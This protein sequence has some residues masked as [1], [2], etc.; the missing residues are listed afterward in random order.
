MGPFV[1]IFW[2]PPLMM[3]W[4]ASDNITFIAGASKIQ[5]GKGQMPLKPLYIS[6]WVWT[7]YLW[8]L[9]VCCIKGHML[10]A[11][12]IFLPL[13]CQ[14]YAV[15]ITH[16]SKTANW[17]CC[18]AT[19]LLFQKV[20]FKSLLKQKIM[21]K[22]GAYL[23]RSYGKLLLFS[24]SKGGGRE[25]GEEAMLWCA[26]QPPKYLETFWRWRR[27]IMSTVKI[28]HIIGHCLFLPAWLSFFIEY[29][30]IEQYM[31]RLTLMCTTW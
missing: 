15:V 16:T 6:T 11:Y 21:I 30:M 22:K 17:L 18:W 8:L 20:L 29:S 3:I 10:C 24:L 23:H 26:A 13:A 28:P 9:L 4:D 31:L 14:Q 25:G 1:W 5:T 19:F 27:L 2:W 12:H 7:K